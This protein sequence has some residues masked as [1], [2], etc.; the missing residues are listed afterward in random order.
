MAE[1]DRAQVS[2]GATRYAPALKLASSLLAES[3]LPRK[4]TILVSDFQ[5]A[6]W[7]PDE[8]FR[9][10]AGSVFTPVAVE[11]PAQA[12]LSITP[13]S[14]QRVAAENQERVAVTAGVSNRGAAAASNVRIDL[15]VDGR[16]VQSATVNVAAGSSASTTFAPV[17][18]TGAAMRVATRIPADGLVVD[19]V[20][21]A[22]VTPPQVLPVMLVGAGARGDSDLYLTRALSIGDRPRFQVTAHGVDA[23]TP[24]S[25]AS[26]PGRHP[27][28]PAAR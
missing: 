14:L 10:P 11:P 17:V 8:A 18:F 22:I 19:N 9:L 5:R 3:S 2:A 20:F 26:G 28:G 16:V 6:G 25:L 24:E 21:N 13:L 15:E 12:N 1:I 23:L 7:Q 4:E 27:A